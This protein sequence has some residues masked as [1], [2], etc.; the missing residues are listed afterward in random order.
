MLFS[1]PFVVIKYCPK[2]QHWRHFIMILFLTN[3]DLTF[4]E[5][6]SFST[7]WNLLF[8]YLWTSLHSSL[9]WWQSS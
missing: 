7:V 1:L 2:L 6:I 9:F 5:P 3:A 8:W 4:C